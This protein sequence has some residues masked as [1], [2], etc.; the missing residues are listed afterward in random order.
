VKL[1][2]AAVTALAGGAKESVTF[3]VTATNANG[4]GRAMTKVATLKGTR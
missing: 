1:P 2:A 4:T 3:T